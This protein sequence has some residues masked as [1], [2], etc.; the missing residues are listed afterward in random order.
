MSAMTLEQDIRHL[1]YLELQFGWKGETDLKLPEMQRL[2]ARGW[3]V[4]GVENCEYS[5]TEEGDRIIASCV[6]AHA[7]M[8]ETVREVITE[9]NCASHQSLQDA[10]DFCG[11][12]AD[13]LS[14][15]IGDTP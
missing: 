13:K 10:A 7:Q 1:I 2:E 5:I 8:V 3:I 6:T 14:R 11:N 15:A 4:E 12:Q 9:M